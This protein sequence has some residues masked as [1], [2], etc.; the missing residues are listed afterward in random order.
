MAAADTIIREAQSAQDYDEQ[1]RRTG[2]FGPEAVFGLV[3][4]YTQPGDRVGPLHEVEEVGGLLLVLAEVE[5]LERRGE[6]R[7]RD[8]ERIGIQLRQGWRYIGRNKAPRRQ[9]LV[10]LFTDDC[11]RHAR[12]VHDRIHR[13]IRR[14]NERPRGCVVPRS[15]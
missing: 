10:A 14:Q 5:E 7:R 6:V 11:V 8:H 1:A 12:A 9:R 4:E 13:R 3:Y 2:W 15:K